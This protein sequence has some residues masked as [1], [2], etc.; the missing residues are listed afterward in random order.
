MKSQKTV[1]YH[2]QGIK[3]VLQIN[4]DT[5][6]RKLMKDEIDFL[7]EKAAS[8]AMKIIPTLPYIEGLLSK[9]KV[10]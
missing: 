4:I 3:I 6:Q 10:K 2:Q 9:V 5:T 8:E 7:S 1:S